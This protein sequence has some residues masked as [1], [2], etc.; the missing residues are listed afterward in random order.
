MVGGANSWRYDSFVNYDFLPSKNFPILV[1][2]KETQTLTESRVDAPIVVD[3]AVGQPHFFP[4][5]RK[6]RAT[7]AAI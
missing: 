2:F 4:A 7:G 1:Y 6:R 5:N 3:S